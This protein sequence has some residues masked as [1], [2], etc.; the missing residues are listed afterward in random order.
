MSDYEKLITVKNHGV[1]WVPRHINRI[2]SH[3]PGGGHAWQV[4][5]DRLSERYFSRLFSDG[6]WGGPREALKQAI[7]CLDR[8]QLK[9]KK[10]DMLTG[11][12]ASGWIL[13]RKNNQRNGILE[14]KAQMVLC[15]H[16]NS[17][18]LVFFHVCTENNHTEEK[19]QAAQELC[20]RIYEWSRNIIKT[21]G[22][23]ELSE[24]KTLPESLNC[25]TICKT[26]VKKDVRENPHNCRN[27]ADRP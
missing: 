13:W 24:Y 22:R 17:R 6:R 19:E 25:L 9:R 4:R 11:T 5:F 14:L 10:T 20:Q 2:D 27:A 7:F 26:K 1:F 21:K 8:E 12:Q 15:T 16:E 23:S 18:S 3:G